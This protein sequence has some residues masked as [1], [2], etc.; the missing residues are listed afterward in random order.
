MGLVDGDMHI[1]QGDWFSALPSELKNSFDLVVS[2]PP[3]I[4]LYD[5]NIESIVRDYEPHL[6]LFAGSDGLDAYRQIISQAGEWL[7]TDGL[8]VLE[9]GHEQGSE[10]RNLLSENSFVDIEIRQDYSQRD[11]IALARKQ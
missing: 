1:V 5:P 3:Y 11:R 2:N 8:L 9:I 7:V 4:A 6:A 10:I